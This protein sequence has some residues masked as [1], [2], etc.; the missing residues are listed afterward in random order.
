VHANLFELLKTSDGGKKF[1]LYMTDA[2]AKY[3]ELVPLQNKEAATVA[4]AI[5]DKWYCCFGAPIDIVPIKAK[6]F[7][8]C[9][10]TNCLKGLAPITSLHCCTTLNA[11]A[12]QKLPIKPS[13]N[14][15]QASA[16]TQLSIGSF[17]FPHLCSHTS[18]HS[19]IK[20]S[21]F[22]LMFGMEQ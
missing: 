15:L 18:F 22:F 11:T 5:F 4:N 16:T 17:T 13:I 12:R 20:L 10:Q 6:N 7:V 3:V 14:I 2:L 1:I 8:I 21:P 9:C 19:S